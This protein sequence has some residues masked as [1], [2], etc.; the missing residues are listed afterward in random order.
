MSTFSNT[1]RTERSVHLPAGKVTLEGDLCLPEG[2][3]GV[4]LFAHGS[5]SSRF[6]PRNRYL[7]RVLNDVNL[8]TVLI[9]L[10]TPGEAA[11]DRR[12]AH[13]RF[14]I[15]LLADRLIAATDW[16]A[17]DPDTHRLRLGY[18]GASTGA[19]ASLVAATQRREMVGA[20]VSR[21]GRPDMAGS[22]LSQ[23]DAPTLLVVGGEDSAVIVLNRRAYAR[24]RCEKELAIVPGATHLFEEPG[25]LGAAATLARDWLQRFLAPVAEQRRKFQ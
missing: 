12:A 6:S 7:A 2:A 9:D 1:I 17:R 13:F 19:A 21:G 5:A 23:V 10:L 25:T 8:G 18:F 3:V 22:L 20:V 4:V 15:G 24:L 16:I 14:D 11:T